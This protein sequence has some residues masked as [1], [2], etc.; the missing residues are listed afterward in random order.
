MKGLFHKVVNRLTAR[1]KARFSHTYLKAKPISAVGILGFPAFYGVWNF[2]FVQPY[3]NI[4]IRL[5]GCTVCAI[6]W[7]ADRLPKK[8]ARFLPAYCYG[9]AVFCLPFFFTF[10]M[11]MNNVN[12]VWISSAVCGT[13]YLMLLMDSWNVFVSYIIGSVLAIVSVLIFSDMDFPT[14]RYLHS[15]PVFAFAL[16]AGF[17]F[18][19][20]D[21]LLQIASRDRR[22][23]VNA[24][25]SS[26][27]HEMRTP[28]LGI[29]LDTQ[30][31]S[32]V[33]TPL[34]SLG[35]AGPLSAEDRA[36][37]TACLAH[38]NR[39]VTFANTM[40]DMLL[41]NISEPRIEATNFRDHGM[42]EVV[43][44][45]L[46]DYPFKGRERDQVIW[47]P[48]TDFA[49]R[50][51]DL[52]MRHVLFNLL[53]NGLRALAAARRGTLSIQL[54]ASGHLDVRSDA[55]QEPAHPVNRLIVR[56]TGTG[57]PAALLPHIFEPFYTTGAIGDS[58]V[59]IGLAFCRR[60][61][62][63]F[64]GTI[65][66]RSEEGVFTEFEIALP[67]PS[68]ALATATRPPPPPP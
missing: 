22:H 53:K 24:V 59:G 9:A 51:S 25:G 14:A 3:E 43:D 56:D 32:D 44:Q 23:A 65:T 62:E 4:Y 16:T 36:D 67:L 33:V 12:E 68:D 37:L 5:I 28:L 7:A 55:G 61:V 50:G 46:A 39:Q 27:A 40:I 57:I 35:D 38:I 1:Y 45:A 29:R 34:L 20:H 19:Y 66:S 41:M 18:D 10:M 31:V 21:E 49:F 47:H 13:I 15:L 42:A 26:V 63:S 11:L 60:V 2:A 6:L 30:T 52:L 8:Y 17:V 54:D 64:G 58:R 48:D